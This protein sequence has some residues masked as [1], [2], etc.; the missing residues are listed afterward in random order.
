[1][2]NANIKFEDMINQYLAYRFGEIKVIDIKLSTSPDDLGMDIVAL[3][4]YEEL[5]WQ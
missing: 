2:P 5:Q 1:M 3:L 4:I